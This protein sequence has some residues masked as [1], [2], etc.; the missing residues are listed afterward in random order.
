MGE[1]DLFQYWIYSQIIH[2]IKVETFNQQ[3]CDDLSSNTSD[4]ISLC[5]YELTVQ[6]V[7]V[8]SSPPW[9]SDSPH[10]KCLSQVLE[11]L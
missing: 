5:Y 6:V 3:P 10:L 4:N 2:M 7:M 1:V 8:V 9:Q 11:G